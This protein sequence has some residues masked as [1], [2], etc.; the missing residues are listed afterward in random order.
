[1]TRKSKKESGILYVL[2]VE[3]EGKS[4]VKIGVTHRKIED[5]VVEILVSIFS[6]YRA[7]PY[8]RPKRFRR[9]NDIYKKEK[10]LHKLFEKH[11]YKTTKKFSGHTEFFDV[12]LEDVVDAYEKLLSGTVDTLPVMGVFARLSKN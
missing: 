3:L 10:T 4:L 2:L 7:F 9:T 8:C 5:R 6:K 12:P 1:M 11:R